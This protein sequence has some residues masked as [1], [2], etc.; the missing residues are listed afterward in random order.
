MSRSS[1]VKLGQTFTD[2]RKDFHDISLPG[3]PAQVTQVTQV[4]VSGMMGMGYTVGNTA[5]NLQI[6]MFRERITIVS[7]E[8]SGTDPITW[9]GSVTNI[10]MA[11]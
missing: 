8:F 9:N 6:A 2:F 7:S 3:A 11:R 5:K 1:P 10:S 4:A